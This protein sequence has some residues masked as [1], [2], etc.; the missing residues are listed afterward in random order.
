MLNELKKTGAVFRLSILCSLSILGGLS[1]AQTA[2]AQ[3][4]AQTAQ[5]PA[6]PAVKEFKQ[7]VYVQKEGTQTYFLAS[8]GVG[9][10]VFN[11]FPRV[12]E[13]IRYEGACADGLAQG[14]GTTYWFTAGT[15]KEVS[16]GMYNKGKLDGLCDLRLVDSP[17]NY[18]GDCREGRPH[19][20]GTMRYTDGNIYT[21]EFI[22]GKAEVSPIK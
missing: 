8:E 17:V 10:K 20:Q 6:A 1:I 2:F 14:K 4:E 12:N 9:C 18:R 22:N 5:T 15:L 16:E 13:T 7:T 19:G 21:G 11:P 3:T